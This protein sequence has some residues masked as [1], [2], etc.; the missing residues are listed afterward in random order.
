MSFSLASCHFLPL[1]STYSPH[2]LFLSTLSL[3]SSL[4]VIVQVSLTPWSRVL[5]QKLIVIQ[6]VRKIPLLLRNPKVH[7]RVHNSPPLA[8]VLSQMNPFCTLPPISL[9]SILILFSHVIPGLPR[10]IFP[11][12]PKYRPSFTI[13]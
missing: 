12:R 1:I 9:T 8:P 6:L 13:I 11:F 10:G 5:L 4:E 2:T 7:H 3:C